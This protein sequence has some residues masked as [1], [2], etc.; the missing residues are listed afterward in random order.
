MD[1]LARP[2]MDPVSRL[3]K[4]IAALR[5][6]SR[7]KAER[8]T[9]GANGS[10]STAGAGRRKTDA[11]LRTEI[12]RRIT[13]VDLSQPEQRYAAVRLFIEQVLSREF[14]HSAVASAAFRRRIADLQRALADDP[15]TQ[16][17]VDSLIKE[18][19]GR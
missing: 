9:S 5:K 11:E 16:A 19:R 15:K 17:Q 10:A 6:P 7:A 18:L 4:A 1:G 13:Q 2:K 14:G 8:K 12:A 3:T